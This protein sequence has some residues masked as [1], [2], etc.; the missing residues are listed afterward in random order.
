MVKEIFHPP[1]ALVRQF[2]GCGHPGPASHDL[3]PGTSPAAHPAEEAAACVL[4]RALTTPREGADSPMHSSCQSPCRAV[5]WGQRQQW[6]CNT[7]LTVPSPGAVDGLLHSTSHHPC[8]RSSGHRNT[9]FL[10]TGRC[11]ALEQADLGTS[12]HPADSTA[13]VG[14]LKSAQRFEQVGWSILGLCLHH[15]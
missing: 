14:V 4:G 6:D 2:L 1:P 12:P 11:A 13:Y 7:G 3:T 9:S 5:G 8:G 10:P 15:C